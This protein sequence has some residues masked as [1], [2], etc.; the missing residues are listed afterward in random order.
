MGWVYDDRNKA[1]VPDAREGEGGL[2]QGRD[3]RGPDRRPV[4]VGASPEGGG[5]ARADRMSPWTD[6]G[7]G[8][9]VRQSRVFWMNS[10]L[11]L[12]RDARGARGPGRAALRAGRPRGRGARRRAARAHP[13]L[14]PRALGPR[15]R[16]ALVA[17]GGDRRA[18]GAGGRAAARGGRDPRGRERLRAR[19]RRGLE[20]RLRAVPAGR[21][22][23]AA[24][25]RSRAGPGGSSLREAPGHCDS[26]LTVHLPERRLLFAADLLS[27]LEI[28]WLDR[29]PAAYPPHAGAP[30]GARRGRGRRAA[31]AG[32]RRDRARRGGRARARAARP[33]LPRRAG[34]GRARGA[35]GGAHAGGDAGAARRR[36]TTSARAPPTRWTTSTAG[37]CASPGS[38]AATRGR[39]VRQRPAGAG[40]AQRYRLFSCP[41][42]LFFTADWQ[43]VP[44][45]CQPIMLSSD[46]WEMISGAGGYDCSP[47]RGS[48]VSS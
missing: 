2:A 24:S 17:G 10:A 12:D 23:C 37:T 40:G 38:G 33:G 45:S 20:R 28:P 31:R 34:G 39:E 15:A 7:G 30:R 13:A 4:Q 11:L 1:L 5:P 25:G 19:A 36:W 21:R 6:L 14:H 43:L 16:A 44:V 32:P 46:C 22:R 8:V 42:V 47:S 41:Q 27:D 18:R 48:G 3:R 35:P 26:Q 9:R 29:E